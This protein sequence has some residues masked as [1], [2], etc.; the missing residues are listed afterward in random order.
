[1]RCCVL[2]EGR[3]VSERFRLRSMGA[4][5]FS[6]PPPDCVR[7]VVNFLEQINEHV[8]GALQVIRVAQALEVNVRVAS[9][10]QQAPEA[11]IVTQVV[12]SASSVIVHGVVM[13]HDK[14][15]LLIVE[16]VFARV[17]FELE[18]PPEEQQPH[19]G[20]GRCF[21]QIRPLEY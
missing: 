9:I 8:D 15:C 11:D 18:L 16:S 17:N 12:C 5:S 14:A 10:G 1:M 3:N 21:I 6:Y 2:N 20:F 13:P 19:G 4:H 7:P